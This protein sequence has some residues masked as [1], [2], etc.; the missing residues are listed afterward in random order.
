MSLGAAAENLLISAPT[1]KRNAALTIAPQGARFSVSHVAGAAQDNSLAAAIPRRQSTRSLYDGRTL[2]T[3]D[4]NTLVSASRSDAVEIRILTARTEI[5]AV[6][7]FI[8]QGNRIQMADPAFVRELKNWIR[9]NPQSAMAAGD[10]LYLA[11]SGNPTLP[12]W[13]AP[14]MFDTAFTPEA[15]EKKYIAQL[16]SS[17]GVAVLTGLDATPERWIEV[18]RACQRFA[19]QATLLGLKHAFVNQPVEAASVRAQFAD[20]LGLSGRRPDLVIRFDYA[21]DLPFS[22][23]RPVHAVLAPI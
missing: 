4:I 19:L 5:D 21:P 15:E 8:V 12:D 18:G 23:R 7:D 14:M 10:G 11:S 16:N 20:Y 17:A 6:R 22:L 9:F 1:L 2:A 13:F 3:V